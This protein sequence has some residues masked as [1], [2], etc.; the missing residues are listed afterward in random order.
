MTPREIVNEYYRLANLNDW[1]KWCDL[2]HEDMVMDEQLGGHLEKLSNLRPIMKGFKQGWQ[3]FQNV[4]E[5]V[6]IEGDKAAVKSH[7]TEI[8]PEGKRI[9]VDV[10]NY[11]RFADGKIIYMKNFHDTAPYK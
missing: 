5:D 4:P 8:T 3:K 2:F 9:E 7:I 10:M 6:I 11:F 1:D